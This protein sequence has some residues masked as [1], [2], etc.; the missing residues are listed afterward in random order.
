M[1]GLISVTVPMELSDVVSTVAV[2]AVV[3]RITVVWPE[4]SVIEASSAAQAVAKVCLIFVFMS[5]AGSPGRGRLVVSAHPDP[6]IGGAPRA[7]AANRSMY[8]N[9]ALASP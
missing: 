9:Q 8:E 6:G 3:S 7:R 5:A 4:A 2:G 1:D